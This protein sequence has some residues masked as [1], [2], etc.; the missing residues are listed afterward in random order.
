M[1]GQGFNA[2]ILA[3]YQVADPTITFVSK[4]TS[5]ITFTITNNNGAEA[6]IYY[7]I[8]DNTPDAAN[9]TLGGGAT[10]SNITLSSLSEATVY[11]IYAQATKSG[12]ESSAVVSL[13]TGTAGWITLVSSI[14]K[15]DNSSSPFGTYLSTTWWMPV[16][17]NSSASSTQWK[18]TAI[19][20]ASGASNEYWSR[21]FV[22]DSGGTSYT[23]SN[24][25]SS[26]SI[27]GYMTSYINTPSN[28]FG[29]DSN[30]AASIGNGNHVGSTLS[31]TFSSAVTL[32]KLWIRT[33]YTK[34]NAMKLEYYN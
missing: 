4:N 16:F 24:G 22:E 32:N 18:L 6:V 21:L 5:S 9:V 14:D 31:L 11:T 1:F 7:E 20:Q 13:A 27:G 3:S 33:G 10:S 17:N 8:G 12:L 23:T 25:I 19:S 28:A 2:G 15:S 30:F 26:V 29:N 34:I